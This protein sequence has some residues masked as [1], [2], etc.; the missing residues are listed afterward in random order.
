MQRKSKLAI[1]SPTRPGIICHWRCLRS[2]F[3]RYAFLFLVVLCGAGIHY[4]LPS[5][6]LMSLTLFA[7][8]ADAVVCK[9]H[10][11]VPPEEFTR[12]R[13][14][15]AMRASI[16]DSTKKLY[17]K[18]SKIVSVANPAHGLKWL[19]E[20]QLIPLLSTFLNISFISF[21]KAYHLFGLVD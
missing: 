6:T 8:I 19:Q 14:V 20:V 9:Y 4:V 7:A 11:D 5:H 3:S 10:E 18:L 12:E 21:L 13:V 17:K 1:K 2:S 15:V 16:K